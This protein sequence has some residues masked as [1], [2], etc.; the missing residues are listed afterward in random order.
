MSGLYHIVLI[1]EDLWL[2]HNISEVSITVTCGGID[3]LKNAID[4]D[5]KLSCLLNHFDTILS[6]DC[7]LQ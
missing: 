5:T 6:I 1:V 3:A 7:K 4:S 2:K